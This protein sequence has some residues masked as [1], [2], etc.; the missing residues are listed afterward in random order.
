MQLFKDWDKTV[1]VRYKNNLRI[2]RT[3]KV[4]CILV[5]LWR[6][7]KITVY[8]FYMPE[9]L[10]LNYDNLN[11]YVFN[12]HFDVYHYIKKEINKIE[13]EDIYRKYRISRQECYIKE[14]KEE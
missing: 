3:E 7:K 13:D 2:I 6:D 14:E 10:Y 5:N 12:K 4:T 9:R 8:Y 1:T 11:M